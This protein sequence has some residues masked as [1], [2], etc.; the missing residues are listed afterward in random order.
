MHTHLVSS[1]GRDVRQAS[2]RRKELMS[3]DRHRV[4]GI[5]EWLTGDEGHDLDDAGFMGATG[6]RLRK[7][8]L[9]VDRLTL[10]LRTLHPEFRGR[11]VVW[12]PGAPVQVADREHDVG[13][14]DVFAR[15]PMRQVMDTRR[16]LVVRLDDPRYAELSMLDLFR[17]QGLVELVIAPLIYGDMPASAVVFCTRRATGFSDADQRAFAAIVPALRGAC[18]IRMLRHAETTLLDTYVGTATGRRI[19]AGRIRRGDAET[20]DAALFLCDLRGFTALSDRLPTADVLSLLNLYFD[21]VVPAIEAAGGEILKFMGDA[22][23]AYFPAGRDPEQ[24]CRAA[25]DA[26]QAA[27]RRLAD[28]SPPSGPLRAG[29]ALHYGTVSYGNIGS[30]HRLDFTVIGRDVNLTSRL[31]GLCE[32]LGEPLLMSKEFAG[33]LDRPDIAPIGAH[34]VKGLSWPIEL[35]A[36]DG[37]QGR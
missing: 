21:Q 30:G 31:Q 32:P 8:G 17:G 22:V 34:A 12:S 4:R 6:R 29:I 16:W 33:R 18:E 14:S 2:R 7:A 27:L 10:H 23:L 20:L 3:F 36:P 24:S 28:A 37:G 1:G 13:Q 35:F 9:P 19:L 15:S 5:L 11:T 25:F 26:A